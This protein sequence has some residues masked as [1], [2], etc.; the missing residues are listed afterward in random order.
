MSKLKEI[1]LI[2]FLE[3]SAA[4]GEL[5]NIS[6]TPEIK[7]SFESAREIETSFSATT[8]EGYKWCFIS[9]DVTPDSKMGKGDIELIINRDH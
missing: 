6:S 9:F 4:H 7:V 2:Q 3:E 5:D 8:D 1:Q